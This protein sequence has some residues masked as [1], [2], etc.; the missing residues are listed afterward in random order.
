MENPHLCNSILFRGAKSNDAKVAVV[1]LHGRRQTPNDIYDC[2]Q[3]IDMDAVRYAVP[4][5]DQ[6]TWYPRG[7]MRPIEDNEPRLSQALEA[8]DATVR[9]LSSEGFSY[10]RVVLMGFSQGACLAC[11]YVYRNPGRWGGLIVFT[12]GLFGPDG[13]VWKATASFHETPVFLGIGDPDEWIPA[14]RV[15]ET[16]DA[17]RA[18]GAEVR[19]RIY[20]GIGHRICDQEI[21]E[22]RQ[23]L[24]ALMT[25][26]NEATPAKTLVTHSGAAL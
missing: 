22:A 19:E 18:A 17:F 24:I 5:A 2:A 12:G 25:T 7:F 23:I 15:K 4:T 6:A 13:T 20:P 9:A 26:S 16:A 21:A 14:S 3:R 11:E 10:D 8:V 1:L